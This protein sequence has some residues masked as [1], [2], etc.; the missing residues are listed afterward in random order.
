MGADAAVQVSGSARGWTCS[1]CRW[2]SGRDRASATRASSSAKP[3]D[4]ATRRCR[5]ARAGAAR[6]A[7]PSWPTHR[8]HRL[9]RRRPAAAGSVSVARQQPCR[10]ATPLCRPASSHRVA[11]GTSPLQGWGDLGGRAGYV[12]GLEYD[13]D[14]WLVVCVCVSVCAVQCSGQVL[15][16][17]KGTGQADTRHAPH[18]CA[19]LQLAPRHLVR[20]D[21][22][23][24]WILPP[25]ICSR[26]V[27]L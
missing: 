1:R 14:C 22:D 4:R 13:E 12:L 8:T 18:A 19:Q 27:V 6:R 7:A 20:P 15:A 16:R 9:H 21:R 5:C 24:D 10:P 2:S 25:Q 3:A 11:F 17:D 23:H 26:S